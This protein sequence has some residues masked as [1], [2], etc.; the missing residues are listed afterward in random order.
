[1]RTIARISLVMAI[2]FNQAT[3]LPSDHAILSRNAPL[4]DGIPLEDSNL[5]LQKPVAASSDTHRNHLVRR[6]AGPWARLARAAARQAHIPA[7]LV[8]AVIQVEN[9]Q[10]LSIAADRVS[11]AGAIGPMQLMPV[12][13]WDVLRVNPWNPKAN[14]EGG[15]RYL[16][17][18]LK[19]FHG[20]ARLALAAYNAG[21]TA[22]DDHLAPACAWAYARDV[23]RLG[24]LRAK[25]VF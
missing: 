16:G 24:H 6:L 8:A 19:R 5:L 23:M 10:N 17:E 11:G 14:I 13:A 22:V 25:M 9:Y 2:L 4:A 3:S 15:A 1:M 21:P 20:N 7:R 18:L 12:T